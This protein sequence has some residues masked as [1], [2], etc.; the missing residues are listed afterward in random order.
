M[1]GCHPSHL[2]RFVAAGALAVLVSGLTAC[3]ADRGAPT[4]APVSAPPAPAEPAELAVP[5]APVRLQ[6]TTY[7]GSG[8]T[9][10]PD[11]AAP[12]APWQRRLFYLA[13]TPYPNGESRH[14]NPSLFVSGNGVGWTA[15]PHAPAPLVRPRAGYLSD[16]DLVH[17]SARNELFLYYREVA[18]SDE[19]QLARSHDGASWDN[20][21]L[22]FRAPRNAALSPAVVRRAA[23]DWMMYTVNGFT[24]CN[25]RA[26][27]L[28]LRRSTDG[29]HWSSPQALDVGAPSLLSPW[30]VDVQWVETRHEYWALYPAK[31]PGGCATTA[32]FLATSP[33][34]VRWRTLPSPVLTAGTVPALADIVYRSTLAY[35]PAADQ[36][37]L[38]ISGATLE[39]G[40]FVWSTV[41][42]KR[43]RAALFSEAL[44]ALRM[45]IRAASRLV[46]AQFTPP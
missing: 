44:R 28:E 40:A 23:D 36:V 5:D 25:D 43:P 8:Q 21:A 16:P 22:L 13:V 3:A 26:A 17:A 19:I 18:D 34:G 29:L 37:T 41:V 45:P 30:H 46:Q 7:D 39:R 6:L 20:G 12:L 1:P 15:A 42:L 4:D 32:L 24:G 33:D 38:W 35:D 27:R 9:V 31:A 11:F 14:E 10:H 2:A